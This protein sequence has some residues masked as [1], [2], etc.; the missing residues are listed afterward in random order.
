LDLLVSW[1]LGGQCRQVS[2]LNAHCV[3]VAQSDPVYRQ[4]LL[5][6]HL[7]LPDGVGV[8]LALGRQGRRMK[9]NLNG[10]DLFPKLCQELSERGGSRMF[11]LGG[12]PGVAEGVARWVA[13]HGPG[14]EVVGTQHGFFH[15]D[16]AVLQQIRESGANLVLVALGVPLQETW[17]ARHL[18]HLD[19]VV[20]CVGGLFDFFSGRQK[21]A[22]LW[23]R[24]LSLEWAYRLW[25]EPGRMWRRYLVGNLVFLS[26]L[27]RLPRSAIG[28]PLLMVSESPPPG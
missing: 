18:Q 15:D 26:R 13:Q 25:R 3:N 10:T 1:V 2:F 27:A 21:R 24:R 28:D 11:L 14:V 5:A 6:S 9:S 19:S 7:V 23:V 8:K 16:Q 22:P 17:V 12:Q 20:L 4:A